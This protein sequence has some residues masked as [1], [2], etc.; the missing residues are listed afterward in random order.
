MKTSYDLLKRDI[1]FYEDK[2]FQ[3]EVI[4]EARYIKNH[5]TAAAKAVKVVKS[6]MD[7]F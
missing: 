4:D 1:P 6:R 2:E 7:S 5:T 3:Y